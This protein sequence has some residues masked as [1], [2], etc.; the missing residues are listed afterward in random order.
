MNLLHHIWCCLSE[1]VFPLHFCVTEWEL[2]CNKVVKIKQE[3]YYSLMCVTAL[4]ILISYLEWTMKM[5]FLAT[6]RH[7]TLYLII[8]FDVSWSHS[9][10]LLHS[11]NEISIQSN[12]SFCFIE[13]RTWFIELNWKDYPSES[14]DMWGISVGE[15]QGTVSH[16]RSWIDDI[17]VGRSETVAHKHTDNHTQF[18]HS[19][20]TAPTWQVTR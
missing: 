3:C 18:I 5:F 7:E 19:T 20:T 11:D 17:S 12:S 4:L 6:K 13:I 14:S 10:N 15:R 8:L 16:K 9:L 2:C 1:K